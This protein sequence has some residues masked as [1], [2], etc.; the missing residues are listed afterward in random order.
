MHKLRIAALLAAF[1]ALASSAQVDE[2][3]CQERGTGAIVTRSAFAHGYRHGYEAG[4]HEGNIDINMARR[5]RTQAK[6]F[7]GL[8]LGY[9]DSFGPKKSF[10]LGFALGLKAGYSDGYVGNNFRAVDELRSAAASLGDSAAPIDPQ[11]LFFDRGVSLGYHDGFA[12]GQSEPRNSTSSVSI[13]SVSCS[14]RPSTPGESAAEPS[15]CDGYRRGYLLGH[16]DGLAI[17]PDHALL[18][19]SK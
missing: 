1:A 6:Q 18:E 2:Q 3:H 11:N 12:H 16:G 14:F 13:N 4:Y 10:E 8:S 7:K 15:Y 19:A 9:E 5:A 17:G